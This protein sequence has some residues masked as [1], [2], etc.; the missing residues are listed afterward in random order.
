[1]N[2]FAGLDMIHIIIGAGVIM[3]IGFVL[4]AVF[5][6]T[7]P[8]IFTSIRVGTI[9]SYVNPICMAKGFKDCNNARFKA[10]EVLIM[11]Y[12]IIGA[13][14]IAFS[15]ILLE[16]FPPLPLI[17]SAGYGVAAWYGIDMMQS[18]GRWKWSPH[19]TSLFVMG[20]SAAGLPATVLAFKLFAKYHKHHK[21][22]Y[23]NKAAMEQQHER[24]QAL[25]EHRHITE[26]HERLREDYTQG[27]L[28]PRHVNNIRQ[29]LVEQP[30]EMQ[31]YI[32]NNY[33]YQAAAENVSAQNA[34]PII[35]PPQQIMQPLP[36]APPPYVSTAPSAPAPY[37]Q[38]QTLGSNIVDGATDAVT[39]EM[40]RNAAHFQRGV[41]NAIATGLQVL[42]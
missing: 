14:Y 39:Q 7:I 23:G 34:R 20:I 35:I 10:L 30:P 12:V 17:L 3:F 2:S 9:L 33:L 22:K 27:A 28:E 16:L 38:L 42:A 6:F 11:T 15:E 37:T 31:P 36:S 18:R 32:A 21:A 19:R 13:A 24:E 41:R 29:Q 1:M 26:Q 25:L 4:T 5:D 40:V 8:L